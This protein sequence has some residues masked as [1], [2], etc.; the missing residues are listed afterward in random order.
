MY[1]FIFITTRGNW[2]NP[3]STIK[4]LSLPDLNRIILR[5]TCYVLTKDIVLW[6]IPQYLL[7]LNH[8]TGL[9]P[10]GQDKNFC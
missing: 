3:E 8:L 10:Y 7:I 2:A 4:V 5:E 1:N 9:Y 6:L